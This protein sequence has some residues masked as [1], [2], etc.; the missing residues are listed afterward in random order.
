MIQT[1][2]QGTVGFSRLVKK[3]L[4]EMAEL[5][6]GGE[7]SGGEPLCR[8]KSAYEKR[9]ACFCSEEDREYQD[10]SFPSQK[11]SNL[12]G[13]RKHPGITE[14]VLASSL[15]ALASNNFFSING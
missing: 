2:V 1:V 14:V 3:E 5:H 11:Y 4:V 6:R 8:V 9:Q 12:D 13:W 15:T 7:G 10:E